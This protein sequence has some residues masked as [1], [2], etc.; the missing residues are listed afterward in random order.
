MNLEGP[1]SPWPFRR[2]PHWTVYAAFMVTLLLGVLAFVEYVFGGNL[3]SSCSI[4]HGCRDRNCG[5]LHEELRRVGASVVRRDKLVPAS[6]SGRDM[7]PV[8][9]ESG[10]LALQ[11]FFVL[12]LH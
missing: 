1:P 3:A 9:V 5:A 7:F 10:R 4:L 12:K 8:F 6:S 2:R 11:Q